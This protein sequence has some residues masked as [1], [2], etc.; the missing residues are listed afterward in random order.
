[1]PHPPITRLRSTD[2]MVWRM[3]SEQ[4]PVL[5]PLVASQGLPPTGAQMGTDLLSG[6]ALCCEPL[7]W[8]KG[9]A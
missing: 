5:W 1:M 6:G 4:T 8:V 3:T 9:R 2:H 7:G